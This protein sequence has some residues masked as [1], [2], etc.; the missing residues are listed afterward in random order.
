MLL[1]SYDVLS[2]ASQA[3]FSFLLSFRGLAPQALRCRLLRRLRDDDQFVN[4]PGPPVSPKQQE[5][6]GTLVLRASLVARLRYD[7]G[8]RSRLIS[9]AL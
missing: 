5:T 4:N 3:S 9:C 6:R 7:R 2:P 1:G 8:D